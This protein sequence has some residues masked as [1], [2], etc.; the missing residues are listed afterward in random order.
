M[1]TQ[2]IEVVIIQEK[3][4]LFRRLRRRLRPMSAEAWYA[5]GC[6]K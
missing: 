4:S 1:P 6:P 2:K 3:V 5:A